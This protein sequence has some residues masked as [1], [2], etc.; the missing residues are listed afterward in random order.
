[1]LGPALGATVAGSLAA[2]AQ[3]ARVPRI[4]ILFLRPAAEL[5]PAE[6][7]LLP[8]LGA[9]GWIDGK[10]AQIEVRY[11]DSDYSRLA[12]LATELVAARVDV[13]VTYA[14]GVLAA[15]QV[16]SSVP[17]VQAT[18]GDPVALGYAGSLARPGKNVTGSAFFFA[19][20]M[21]KRLELIKELD[22]AL[23]SVLVLL[24]RTAY[25]GNVPA[26]AALEPAARALGVALHLSEVAGPDEFESVIAEAVAARS[27]AI[28][29]SDHDAFVNQMN[30]RR[31][32]EIA[33]RQRLPS[34]GA[35]LTCREGALMGY[36]VNFEE[37]FRRAATF[38]DRILKG[39][40]AADLP[41]EQ[42]TIFVLVINL[43]TAK[44]L[45]LAIP[46]ALLARA[47]EVIE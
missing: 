35:V 41:F 47:D 45:G 21:A 34:I 18:G 19:E 44:A 1:M 32:A 30:A 22:P 7:E 9:L 16:T 20:L 2:H 28:V 10:T 25:Q 14:T 31:L 42:A 46:P 8:S 29:V 37:Q 40:S 6:R 27:R 39:A 43:G 17:I 15:A 26:R 24:S 38:V 33:I 11:A 4:G 23:S 3:Q 12:P 5:G 36:G 13:L